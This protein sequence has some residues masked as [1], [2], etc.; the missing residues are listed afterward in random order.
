MLRQMCALVGE[1]WLFRRVNHIMIPLPLDI[2]Q[3]ERMKKAF[4]EGGGGFEAQNPSI[5]GSLF[6]YDRRNWTQAVFQTKLN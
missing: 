5:C 4:S 3:D 1:R 6:L 2:R